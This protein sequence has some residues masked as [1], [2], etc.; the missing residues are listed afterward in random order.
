MK[1]DEIIGSVSATYS[2]IL[3]DLIG[4]LGV[5]KKLRE[6]PLGDLI[7]SARCTGFRNFFGPSKELTANVMRFAPSM[8]E[9]AAVTFAQQFA[10]AVKDKSQHATLSNLLAPGVTQGMYNELQAVVF[11]PFRDTTLDGLKP[12]VEKLMAQYQVPEASGSVLE[13]MALTFQVLEK[14]IL[15]EFVKKT[16]EVSLAQ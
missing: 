7:T 2:T 3:V 13:K 6:G 9:R 15:Q 5:A 14:A 8:T 11:Q 1:T 16:I 12:T 10:K 4:K